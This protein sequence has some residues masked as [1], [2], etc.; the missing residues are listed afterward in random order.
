MELTGWEDAGGSGREG[1]SAELT[2][3]LGTEIDSVEHWK[4]VMG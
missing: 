3:P 2:G 1:S 4:S